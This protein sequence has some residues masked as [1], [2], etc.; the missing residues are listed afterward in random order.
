M[1][2]PPPRRTAAVRLVGPPLCGRPGRSFWESRKTAK[3]PKGLRRR[4]LGE[5][6][7]VDLLD[8]RDR[9]W[10]DRGDESDQSP[11]SSWRRHQTPDS[12]RPRGARSSHWYMPHRPSSPRA[13]AEYVW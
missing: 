12:F 11:Y 10:C 7:G 5:E 8:D 3:E 1:P 9:A 6:I 13:Y 4:K 2:M